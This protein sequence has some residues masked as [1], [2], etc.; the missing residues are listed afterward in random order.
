[1]ASSDDERA[2]SPF[3]GGV[4]PGPFLSNATSPPTS[5]TSPAGRAA[6]QP[7]GAL[8]DPMGADNSR[9][10]PRS[11][12][13]GADFLARM[14][15]TPPEDVVG[16]SPGAK[17]TGRRLAPGSDVFSGSPGGY[18]GGGRSGVRDRLLAAGSDS[19]SNS[20]SS[21]DS[22]EMSADSTEDAEEQFLDRLA[23]AQGR[24]GTFSR[25]RIEGEL[26]AVPLSQQLW[27]LHRRRNIE[28][29]RA[30][31]GDGEMRD[32]PYAFAS[33]GSKLV[34]QRSQLLQ[35]C[36]RSIRE[37]RHYD[38]SRE[39]Y[40]SNVVV[41]PPVDKTKAHGHRHHHSHE[42]GMRKRG[43][44]GGGPDSSSVSAS[45]H[46]H[47]HTGGIRQG[48]E[49]DSRLARR[50]GK[51]HT[52][53]QLLPELTSSLTT[54]ALTRGELLLAQGDLDRQERELLVRCGADEAEIVDLV[55]MEELILS[56]KLE[57]EQ[58]EAIEA[59]LD[60]AQ[61]IYG[62]N[63]RKLWQGEDEPKKRRRRPIDEHEEQN[64]SLIVLALSFFLHIIGAAIALVKFGR[65]YLTTALAGVVISSILWFVII[66]ISYAA[67]HSDNSAFTG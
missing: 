14:R 66:F 11:A 35:S 16:T 26:D 20:G 52:L 25:I 22:D 23:H 65:R 24:G 67:L 49:A 27:L 43:G 2:A 33:E 30:H 1:M 12:G 10:V 9:F 55:G 53:H 34:A 59:E 39:Y 40:L 42:D 18:A 58:T 54:D 31:V 62:A 57:P 3:A 41:G 45:V 51:L 7:T 28:A 13:G 48:L 36:A 29:W 17:A 61:A 63:A 60:H 4:N 19:D 50:G 32:G 56:H 6:S 8:R 38:I 44:G 5:F 37:W 46:G 47:G 64:T 15:A 21:F